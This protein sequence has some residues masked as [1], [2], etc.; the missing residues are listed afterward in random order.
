MMRVSLLLMVVMVASRTV[1]AETLVFNDEFDSLTEA[2]N[3]E[4]SMSGGGNNEFQ[5]Y[6]NN[7]TISFVKD[8]VLF[9]KPQIRYDDDYLSSG[10]VNLWG[11]LTYPNDA[12]TDAA[13]DG[14][15]RTGT[16]SRIL[17]PINSA[18]LTSSFS[19]KYGRLEARMK[20]P[21]GDWIWPALWLM[22]KYNL[23]GT[24]PASGEIDLMESRGNAPVHDF[25]TTL[26][27]GPDYRY[28]MMYV[29]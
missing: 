10:T 17:P 27:F 25:G 7:R 26:H 21:K 23:Y 19:F 1:M 13:N 22:P 16:K 11:H 15:L 5:A 20:L 8:G 29:I 6:I 28:V 24:W 4:I 3:H 12:C 2:W 14:C 9:I 18:K